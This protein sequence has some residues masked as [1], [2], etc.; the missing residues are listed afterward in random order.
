M[1]IILH[2]LSV[3]LVYLGVNGPNGIAPAPYVLS[4]QDPYTVGIQLAGQP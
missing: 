3:P 1:N 2:G 4:A